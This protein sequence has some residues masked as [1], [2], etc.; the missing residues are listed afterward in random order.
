[1]GKRFADFVLDN[2]STVESTRLTQEFIDRYKN[3][4]E[5]AECFNTED[6]QEW[7]NNIENIS[8]SSTTSPQR[9]P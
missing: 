4:P 7:S 6:I 2:L 9:G 5:Y 8:P 1:L 3:K